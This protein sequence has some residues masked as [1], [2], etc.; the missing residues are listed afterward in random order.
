MRGVYVDASA[1][2]TTWPPE[3]LDE[4]VLALAP[5]AAS[6]VWPKEPSVLTGEI[7]LPDALVVPAPVVGL[8][9]MHPKSPSIPPTSPP[10]TALLKGLPMAIDT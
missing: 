2:V 4:M 9:D 8:I 1:P 10:M 6:I 7:T 5:T 3:M